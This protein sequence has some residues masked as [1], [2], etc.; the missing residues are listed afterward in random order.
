MNSR[1]AA[2]LLYESEATLRMVDHALDELRLQESRPRPDLAAVSQLAEPA[3]RGPELSQTLRLR[4]F[5]QIQELLDYVRETR[6]A[7]SCPPGAEPAGRN[8][9]AATYYLAEAEAGLTHLGHL[10]ES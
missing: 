3:D 9:A 1:L 7:L 5:W 10:F 8:L 2:E 6:A 4:V